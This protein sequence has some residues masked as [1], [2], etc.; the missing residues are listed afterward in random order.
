LGPASWVQSDSAAVPPVRDSSTPGGRQRV[1]VL[2]FDAIAPKLAFM[3][4][5]YTERAA[6]YNSR[7]DF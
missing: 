3:R 4:D 7:F 5:L 2:I 1:K 6:A